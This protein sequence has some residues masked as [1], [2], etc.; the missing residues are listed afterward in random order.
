MNQDSVSHQNWLVVGL[1]NP[2]DEYIETRHNIGFKVVDE[3]ARRLDARIKRTE[4]R[5][6]IGTSIFEDQRVEL[7]KPQTY[8]NISGEAVQCLLRKDNRSLAKTIV[9]V[10]D[11]ALP[12]EVIRLRGKGSAGG[13]NGL[14]SII[15]Q[16]G[17]N[18]FMRLRVGI[19]PEHPLKNTKKFVLERFSR[20]ESKEL[21]DIIHRCADAVEMVISRGIDAAMG[22]FNRKEA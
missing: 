7:V 12:F 11:L 21:G 4:C 13:H 14:K 18:E 9:I 1:G 2:G 3:L 15:G 6:L 17:T 5:S 20:N 16:T 22:E 19:A 10:D 8:M